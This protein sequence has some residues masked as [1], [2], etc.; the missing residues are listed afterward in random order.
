MTPIGQDHTSILRRAEFE[1]IANLIEGA[2]LVLEVGGG[3][4]FQRLLLDRFA[5]RVVSI[6]IKPHPEPVADVLIYDGHN[7]P[8]GKGDADCIFTSNVLEHI[9]D[10]DGSLDEMRR[11]LSDNGSAI[12]VLPTSS[13]RIWTTITHYVALPKI[14]LSRLIE[15]RGMNAAAANRQ[16][17]AQTNGESPPPVRKT[18]FKWKWLGSFLMSPRHGERGNRLTEV[19]Y[20]RKRWWLQK[21]ENTGWEVADSFPTGIFYS[22]NIVLG[23]SLP[24]NFRKKLSKLF[25]SSTR[26]YVLK[27]AGGTD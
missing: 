13:W 22:G 10:L 23:K 1:T 5:G 6:D 21:F 2:G 11:V 14:L 26:V 16:V 8:L 19:F 15:L 18:F 17:P 25:G 12:H 9:V 24:L 4:G 3:N 20:F 7:I 27:K